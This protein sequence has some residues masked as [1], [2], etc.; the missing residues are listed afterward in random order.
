MVLLSLGPLEK[1][2]GSWCGMPASSRFHN[3]A[4]QNP[5]ECWRLERPATLSVVGFIFTLYSLFFWW[6][7]GLTTQLPDKF[8]QRFILTYKCESLAWR[9]FWP[10]FPNLNC[11]IYLF[12][13]AV[14]FPY[15]CTF[16][17]CLLHGLLC[18]RVAG[19]W[20]PLPPLSPWSSLPRFILWF[21]LSTCQ[22]HRFFLLPCY[23]PLVLY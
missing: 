2:G 22:P 1:E 17:W 10:A 8:T 13:W 18:S 15:F 12:L 11:P 9:F 16:L 21:T 4:N 6:G 5:P 3:N 19:L 14:T 20:G 23:E 7:G